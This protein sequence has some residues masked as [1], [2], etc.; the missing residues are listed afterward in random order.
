MRRAALYDFNP[1]RLYKNLLLVPKS[2][3]AILDGIL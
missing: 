3:Q 1:A 2:K